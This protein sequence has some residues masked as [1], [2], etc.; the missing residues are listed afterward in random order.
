[1]SK[2]IELTLARAECLEAMVHG[3]GVDKD[4]QCGFWQLREW[5][6]RRNS[7][8][9]CRMFSTA[10]VRWLVE[11]GLAEFQ[12]AAERRAVATEAGRAMLGVES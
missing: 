8:L 2:T 11:H 7:F 10:T 4:P 12:D 5:G 3:C 1:M 6:G 9:R